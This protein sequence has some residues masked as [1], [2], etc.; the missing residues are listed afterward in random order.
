HLHL[1]HNAP[2]CNLISKRLQSHLQA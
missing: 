2:V 1:Y